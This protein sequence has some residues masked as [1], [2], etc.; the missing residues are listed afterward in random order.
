MKNLLRVL[1]VVA[2]AAPAFSQPQSRSFVQQDPSLASELPA[3][4][5][6]APEAKPSAAAP[7]LPVSVP[8]PVPELQARVTPDLPLRPRQESTLLPTATVLQ[9]KLN[10]EISTATV[11]PGQRVEATLSKPVEVDGRLVIPAGASV[12]CRVE[13]A[14]NPRRFAGRPMLILKARSVHLPEGGDLF[15]TASMIDT[16]TPHHLDVDQEG[17]LRGATHDRMD[18]VELVAFTGSGAIA[19]A[20]IAG[21]E[22]LLVGTAGGAIAA[23]GH[24][25]VKH[26]HLV[27]PKGIELIFELDA[28]ATTT[29]TQTS[30][31]D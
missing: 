30:G 29:V 22:G 2:L 23:T 9:M 26:R 27:L 7:I 1:C 15:F 20:V 5:A 14:R 28:P 3:A 12:T 18:D 13:A 10:Q 11:R 6:P 24:N 4:Q 25:M 17:R 16:G 31:M 8:A 19:G 21:P